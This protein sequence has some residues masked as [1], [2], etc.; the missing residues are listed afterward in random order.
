M[1]KPL[2]FLTLALLPL[3]TGTSLRAQTFST[4]QYG[5]IADNSTTLIPLVVSGLPNTIDSTFGLCSI[6]VNIV[7]T[8]DGDLDIK[9][10]A[11]NGDSVLL[12][13]NQGG[14]GDNY[15]GTCFA[16]N[17]SASVLNSVPPFSGTIIPEGD[18]NHLNG[19]INPN[20]TWWIAVE[21]Q[22]PQDTG[23]IDMFSLTFCNNPPATPPGPCGIG[24]GISCQCPDGTQDCDLLPDMIASSDIIQNQHTETPGL[25]TLSNATP[26]I[27]WGPMEIHSSNSCWCDTVSVP[28]STSLCPN[29]NP[30][31]Q[32]LLQRIYHKNGNTITYRDTLTHG[33]MS[34]HPSHGHVHINNWA[35]F[36]LRTATSNPDATT[37]PIVRSGSKVSFCLINLGD[38]TN[39]YGYCRDS[40]G[41][42]LTMA[43]VPNAPFGVVSGCGLDQGIYTGMLDIYDQN[44]PD[45]YIDLNGVCN[46]NYY[47]VSITDPD[48]NFLE[49][50]EYN[51]W[52]AAPLTLSMQSQPI[53]SGFNVSQNGTSVLLT[54]NNTDLTGFT[55][56]FGD[57][58]PVDT[59]NNPATHV[60]TT[61]GTYTI[62]LTQENPC[63]TYTS[64]QVITISGIGESPDFN[65]LT[66]K[67]QPNPS[68]GNT[69]ISY[70]LPESDNVTLELYNMLGDR[71]KV[72]DAGRRGS[73][74][75]KVDL[76]LTDSN[77]SNGQY[78][79]RLS[80]TNRVSTLRLALV[81]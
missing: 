66:L 36:T 71:V 80:T 68:A 11:P 5:H 17:G 12:S 62:T 48:N 21:D 73:G 37:W 55:W 78:F 7:H 43:N 1:K 40:L 57:G 59:T 14:A 8:Y 44:L 19:G 30:P 42:V 60:Y 29:G 39:D 46:G 63:G 45:M 41:N 27:G 54:N 13:N 15:A 3:L 6:C 69:T 34:Y 33:T 22:A 56:D 49:S 58:S 81:R 32:K 75:H 35:W 67:A 18:I 50:K 20:G 31:T 23:H 76:D 79:V 74:W 72:I 61:P 4:T 52:V 24:S 26:N 28:C 53:G 9:I 10:Y 47:I 77:L 51:N 70:L 38:C 2:R 25:L 65:Q 16:E 64:T